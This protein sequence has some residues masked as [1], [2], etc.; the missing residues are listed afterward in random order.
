MS[1][2]TESSLRGAG[3]RWLQVS[4]VAC[5]FVG[6]LLWAGPDIGRADL[7]DGDAAHHIFWFYQF[8][9]PDLFVND[10]SV[11]YFASEPVAPAGYKLLYATLAPI[12]DVLAAAEW[13]SVLL[14]G[15]SAGLAWSLGRAIGHGDERSLMGLACVVA[16][17]VLL[18][19]AD[20]L[21]VMGFQ[22]TFAMPLTLLCLWAL[23][24]RR[25][26]W[27]GVAWLGAALFYPI[28]IAV[29]G[30]ASS[31]V[32]L[33]DLVRERRMP[34]Y[35]VWNGILGVTAIA[36][37]LLYSK[38]P[39][40][41]GPSVT[42]DQAMM[43]PEF[44]PGGRQS[45]FGSNWSSSLFRH[46][47]TGLGW[48]PWLIV[49]AFAAAG[50][51]C[52]RGDARRLSAPVLVLF[53]TGLTLWFVARISLF[54]LYLPNRHSRYSIGAV[55][56]VVLATAGVAAARMVGLALW[57]ETSVRLRRVALC[58]AIVAPL[59]VAA[60]LAPGALADIRRP[61]DRDLENTY[62]FL[63]TL[64]KDTLVGAHPDLA[65]YI[66]LRSKRSVLASTEGWIAFKLGYH[67]RMTPRVAASLEAAYATNW[68]D[69]AS[70]LAP[71][72]VDVF[73]STESIF[74]KAGYYPPL[75]DLASRLLLRGHAQGF[76]L[77]SPPPE[78]VLFR[79]GE[80]VVVAVAHEDMRR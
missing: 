52:L 5:I 20:L 26:A 6:A 15:L 30:L 23:I 32:F 10:L 77:R 75:D 12:V 66:P 44:S 51:A 36:V 49:V 21:P 64:P 76:M 47:R 8:A 42:F 16:L 27:V 54:D 63:T 78:R 59:V 3:E 1:A 45:L 58:A 7:F 69:F 33:I 68:N 25:Y 50:F 4:A 9:D 65:D 40:A 70:A 79:S 38:T 29:L 13:I 56:I 53:A 73:V 62:A 17:F 34:S 74:R 72:G 18:P 37:I 55:L 14:L 80:Y 60:T 39:A 43:M 28:I 35:W 71:Y 61:V 22:R 11:E 2:D 41:I 48:S 19:E 24:S 46:H 31:I 67:E 57:R